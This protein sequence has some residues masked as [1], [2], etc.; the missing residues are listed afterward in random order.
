MP[1][2]IF[3][4]VFVPSFAVIYGLLR[5]FNPAQTQV[6]RR[7]RQ[8]RRRP[9]T[10]QRSKDEDEEEFAGSSEEDAATIR[11]LRQRLL[12]QVEKRLERR[13]FFG[14]LQS[15]LVKAGLNLRAAEF[16][17]MTLG[18]A[19]AASL[20]AWLCSGSFLAAVLC[21]A[22]GVVLP[23]QY[24]KSRVSRRLD[25]LEGQLSDALNLITNSLKSGY[26][27][28]QAAD[29][30]ADEMPAPIA[31]EFGRL[32]KE[33]RV[34]I[35]L[36]EALENMGERV[37]SDDLELIITAVLI[38]KQVGGNLATVLE[39]IRETIDER[40]RILRKARTLTSQGRLSGWIISL[41][42]PGLT[43]VMLIM[44]PGY[45]DPLFNDPIGLVV[46]VMAV[47]MEVLGIVIIRNMVNIEV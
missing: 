28:L 45:I 47:L 37:D 4:A 24:L 30:V 38:Q 27:F 1:W 20:L 32:V 7:L 2:W 34:N 8:L 12:E 33:T 22:M 5:Y 26:S 25:E 36:E 35:S 13:A 15:D 18:A 21:F 43:A 23:F 41:L 42:P 9:W 17:A 16:L 40:L 29:V 14:D 3:P 6:E 11:G 31:D 39:T 10:R 19:I 46:L 44:N